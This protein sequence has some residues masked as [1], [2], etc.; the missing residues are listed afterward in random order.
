MNEA[1]DQ[2][3]VDF[4]PK[5]GPKDLIGKWDKDGIVFPDGKHPHHT[6]QTRRNRSFRLD[7]VQSHQDASGTNLVP[8]C[9]R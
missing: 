5:G 4:S 9:C 8:V 1:A 2:I 3:F 7:N 6:L